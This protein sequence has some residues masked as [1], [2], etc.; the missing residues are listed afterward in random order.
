V[1]STNWAAMLLIIA[2]A[3]LVVEWLTRASRWG[4]LP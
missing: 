1:E 2:A 3:A 4:A